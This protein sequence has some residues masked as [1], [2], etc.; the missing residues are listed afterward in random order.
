MANIWDKFENILFGD[1][2]VN[3]LTKSD[4]DKLIKQGVPAEALDKDIIQSGSRGKMLEALG[5]F[6]SNTGRGVSAKRV[7]K[8]LASA[9]KKGSKKGGGISGEVASA[10]RATAR[11]KAAKRSEA[12]KKAAQTR[13]SNRSKI[14]KT[15]RFDPTD[16]MTAKARY[17]SGR[18]SERIP[19]MQQGTVPRSGRPLQTQGGQTGVSPTPR[20]VVK[21]IRGTQIGGIGAAGLGVG[22]Y[23]LGATGVPQAPPTY[24]EKAAMDVRQRNMQDPTYN[25]KAAMDARQQGM[26]GA[27]T[28]SLIPGGQQNGDSKPT[29]DAMKVKTDG[30][31][32]IDW[33]K[34]LAPMIAGIGGTAIAGAVGGGGAAAGF[35]QGFGQQRERLRQEKRQDQRYTMQRFDMAIELGQP[36]VAQSILEGMPELPDDQRDSMVEAINSVRSDIKENDTQKYQQNLMRSYQNGIALASLGQF[37]QAVDIINSAITDDDKKIDVNDAK[38]MGL[39]DW[40]AKYMEA[41]GGYLEPAQAMESAKATM[42]A[43]SQG[44]NTVALERVKSFL[45]DVTTAQELETVKQEIKGSNVFFSIANSPQLEELYKQTEL[46]L[47]E[48]GGNDGFAISAGKFV[49]S[50]AGIP[51]LISGIADIAEDFTKGIYRGASSA[52]RGE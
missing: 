14:V 30:K 31:G 17:A 45:A 2:K 6:A 12:A 3:T 42:T 52:I 10:E 13:K 7:G 22:G 49:G 32:G 5:R 46:R 23:L 9:G 16:P 51:D 19:Q 36:D 48:E 11:A 37:D 44:E 20:T 41:G 1:G 39:N 34:T 4:R 47:K 28:P 43:M 29:T 27:T 35:A 18:A 50:G 40:Y 38:T 15:D 21:D 33:F 25:E 8:S 24:N 26:Q